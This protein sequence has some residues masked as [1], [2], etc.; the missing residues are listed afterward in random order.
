MR[1]KWGAGLLATLAWGL[2]AAASGGG[3]NAHA[4]AQVHWPLPPARLEDVLAHQDFRILSLKGGVGGVSGVK[5]L[6]VV[7]P[8]SG[9]ELDLK[10]KESPSGDADGWNNTPRKEIAAYELQK[11]FL[12]PDDYI[13]PTAVVHCI[14]VSEYGPIRQNPRPTIEGTTCVVGTLVVWLE[15]VGVPKVLYDP[16]RFA[17]EERYRT[18]MANFNLLTYLIEH[19]DGREGNFLTADDPG[20]RRI[21][22]I[23]N[24]V[25]F[26]S[27][28]TNWFVPNW[29]K[30]RVPSLSR[31]S[32]DRLRKVTPEQL[33]ALGVVAEMKADDAGVLRVVPPGANEAPRKGARV[34]PGWLQLGLERGEIEDVKERLDH[35][36][37]DVDAGRWPL[38]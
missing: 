33:D 9:Q 4:G 32:I 35:L 17:N 25:A 1:S 15:N 2:V 14:P 16:E 36:L 8:E 11:W 5:K 12:D 23:D 24:G 27:L 26:G 20:D 19:K 34:K 13:V 21:Y 28:L 31:Q 6:H 37:A 22:S 3:A 18:H 7:F 29:Q 10:W 30:I 38:F